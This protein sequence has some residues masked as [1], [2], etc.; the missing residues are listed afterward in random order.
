MV[1][2]NRDRTTWAEKA[3]TEEQGARRTIRRYQ[4]SERE[5]VGQRKDIINKRTVAKQQEDQK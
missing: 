1:G 5:R 3:K 2:S 4:Q